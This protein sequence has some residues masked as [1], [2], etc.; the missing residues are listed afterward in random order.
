MRIERYTATDTKSAMAL[1]R[2][3]LGSDAMILS[4][5]RIGNRIELTAAVDLEELMADKPEPKAAP[6]PTPQ[7]ERRPQAIR[8]MGSSGTAASAPQVRRDEPANE[9]QLKALERELTRLRG[10]LESELGDRSWQDS[11]GLTGEIAGIRQRLLRLGLSRTLAGELL[12]DIP[13]RQAMDT[14]WQHC[15]S[16]LARRIDVMPDRSPLGAITAVFGCTGVGKTSVIAKLAGRDIRRHG[17]AGVGLISLDSY[18]IGAREQLASFA[19]A[20]GIPLHMV[21]D[22]ESL[23][24]ALKA[25]RGR[26]VYIDTAGMAQGDERLQSQLAL[27][28]SQRA[29]IQSLLVVSASSQPS[30]SRAL[31][32][33]FGNGAMSGAIITK[34]DEAPSLGGVLDVVIRAGLPVHGLCDGQRVPDDYHAADPQTLVRRAVS[35][36]QFDEH[37]ARERT[38]LAVSARA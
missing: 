26:R 5:R 9:I 3:D 15:L 38:P 31:V 1:V 24:Q 4:N 37:V 27:L 36:A 25:M 28:A 13:Q 17:T 22:R 18:R 6:Q 16:A 10:I 12:V 7:G 30:Q 35:L 19:D 8:S 32:D 29:A 23:T 33:S 11:A 21:S 34:V 2:A 14:A 20:L